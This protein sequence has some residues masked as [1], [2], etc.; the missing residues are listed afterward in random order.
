MFANQV[1]FNYRVAEAPGTPH[2]AQPGL[3]PGGKGQVRSRLLRLGGGRGRLN[4]ICPQIY[5]PAGSKSPEE[6]GRDESTETRVAWN[7]RST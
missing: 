5:V 2:E 7:L 3:W 4:K 6:D 1:Q